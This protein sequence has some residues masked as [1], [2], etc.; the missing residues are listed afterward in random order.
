M[1][2]DAVNPEALDA[3]LRRTFARF[4][5]L[6]RRDGA[7][8]VIGKHFEDIIQTFY[9]NVLRPGDCAIDIGANYGMHTLPMADAVGP[10]GR[11]LAFE[12]IPH[13]NEKLTARIR[14]VGKRDIVELHRVALSDHSGH[15]E[16]NV[17]VADV[18]YSGLKAKPYPFETGKQLIRVAVER[19]DRFTEQHD[20]IRFI[21]ID[22]EGAEFP[23]L[24]GATKTL[25]THRPV[26]VF[27]SAKEESARAY[28]YTANELFE[29]FAGLD[30]ELRDILG[31]PFLAEHW[32]SFSPWYVV[33]TP[34]ENAGV[35]ATALAASIAEHSIGFTW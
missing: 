28:G 8:Q 16:F 31:C 22:V 35:L 2:A 23:V 21:K 20:S 33:A 25:Q 30:Y 9:C 19:L 18:G 11:V 1:L 3:C 32:A 13:V 15:A 12:P 17:V 27:E 6:M 10:R 14:D 24:R 29:F 34:A 7:G 4:E 5:Q 26:V